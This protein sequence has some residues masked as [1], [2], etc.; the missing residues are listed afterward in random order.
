MGTSIDESTVGDPKSSAFYTG[1]AM[2][3]RLA[4]LHRC[5]EITAV[6]DR[7]PSE[8]RE[9]EKERGMERESKRERERERE[10]ERD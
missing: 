8:E 7:Y 1:Q 3:A 6:I 4:V 5:S 9:S 2:N 10:R